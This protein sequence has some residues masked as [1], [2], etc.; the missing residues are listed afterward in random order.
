MV[1]AAEKPP[2]VPYPVNEALQQGVYL[3]SDTFTYAASATEI[4]KLAE[5]TELISIR[6]L[7]TT[8]WGDESEVIIDDSAGNV[9]MRL[10]GITLGQ[11]VTPAVQWVGRRF[12]A[13]T[14]IRATGNNGGSPSTGGAC[15]ISIMYRPY[16]NKRAPLEKT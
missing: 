6:V 15:E 10:K 7:P 5:N 11:I 4:F 2:Q 13:A 9:L 14:A 3:I 8:A 12:T 16:A 1:K